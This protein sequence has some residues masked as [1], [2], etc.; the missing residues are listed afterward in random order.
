LCGPATNY[1]PNEKTIAAN[2]LAVCSNN[3]LEFSKNNILLRA[4]FG[5]SIILFSTLIFN[6]IFIN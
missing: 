6:Q 1:G 5:F 3:I 2:P 4:I